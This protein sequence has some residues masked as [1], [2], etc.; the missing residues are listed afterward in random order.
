MRAIDHGVR[1]PCPLSDQPDRPVEQDEMVGAGGESVGHAVDFGHHLDRPRGLG[2]GKD[3]CDRLV[4]VGR[5]MRLGVE[6]PDMGAGEGD[7]GCRRQNPDDRR[8]GGGGLAGV[9]VAHPQRDRVMPGLVEGAAPGAGQHGVAVRRD[10]VRHAPGVV[11]DA[12]AGIG[13]RRE[14]DGQRRDADGRRVDDDGAV[15]PGGGD[16]FVAPHVEARALR[17]RYTRQIV[18]QPGNRLARV[19]ARG[20]EK[21]P[22]VAGGGIGKVWITLDVPAAVGV[23]R[24]SDTGIGDRAARAHQVAPGERRIP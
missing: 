9:A 23:R 22:E 12:G 18:G 19:A 7:I 15:R 16:G 2:V 21:Q 3:G 1:R 20:A 8:C 5:G 4:E 10:A 17:P 14:I 11:R 24:R 13:K 6:G